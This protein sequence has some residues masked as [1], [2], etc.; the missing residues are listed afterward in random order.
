MIWYQGANLALK[1]RYYANITLYTII[2]LYH[3]YANSFKLNK[4]I[5]VELIMVILL[6]IATTFTTNSPVS[7]ARHVLSRGPTEA[8]FVF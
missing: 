4:S 2:V 1:V 6:C 5:G 7:P 3:H 8:V